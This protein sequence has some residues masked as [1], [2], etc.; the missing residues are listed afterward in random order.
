[1]A[2]IVPTMPLRVNWW[3]NSSFR[4]V[5]PVLPA[6]DYAD[7]PAQ[8]R[9]GFKP[10][11]TTQVLSLAGW[12]RELVIPKT[13]ALELPTLDDNKWWVNADLVEIESSSGR[14]YIVVDVERVAYG[15]PNEYLV[16]TI[17]PTR[18]FEGTNYNTLPGYPWFP[19]WTGGV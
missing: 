5:W 1:M 14:W 3:M 10:A 8:L 9:P 15:F 13:T 12:P 17:I 11:M 6:P 16:A 18:E 7:L 4:P 2:Y 19:T